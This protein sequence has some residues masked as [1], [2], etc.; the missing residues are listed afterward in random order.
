MKITIIG[1]GYVGLV[2]GACLAEM[3]NDVFCVDVD[4]RKIDILNDGGV[5]I[6]EPGLK[7]LI[8]RNRASQRLHF[9]TDIEASV[10]H[11]DI[12]FIAIGTPPDEDGSANLQYVLAA[13]RNIGLYMDGP[14]VVVDK[15]TVPVGTAL[16]V[17][18]AIATELTRRGL[19]HEFSV[20]SNPEFLKEGAAVDDFMRPDRIVIGT[21][22]DDAGER[23]REQMKRL[24]APFNRNHERTRY[25]DVRSA[26][27]TKYA[28]NAMLA[29]RISFMNDLANLA[30]QVGANIEAVRRGIGSDPRIGYDFL[31]AGVGY[32]GSCFPKDVRALVQT[33][34]EYG[35]SLR[36]LEAVEAVNDAQKKVLLEK[37]NERFGDDLSGLTF[38]LWGLAFK[39]NTDDM[40]EAPSRELVAGL[41]KRGASVRAYDPIATDEARRVLA[42]DL[43]D[44]PAAHSRLEFVTTSEYAAA[45]ADAL[46]IVTEWKVFKSPNFAALVELLS[47]PVIFDGRNLYEPETMAEL[48][49]EYY[50]IGRPY[51]TG[52]RKA[53]RTLRVAK[54]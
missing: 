39:P 18:D 47:E 52:M 27:F 8:D 15:S 31:Y 37:I 3:G 14:K 13:A 48:G 4:Q 36:I 20:V 43:G 40:R 25:M 49:I 44:D 23:S 26:E 12:Q 22:G 21:D 38:G 34:A 19:R 6:H 53:V 35:R 24:Y 33:A 54:G 29:T 17:R 2:T 7:E 9:S 46:V 32:G 5:P 45:G 30:G 41:L 50:S 28:A 11:G 51:V 42:I 10:A 1:T 16:H